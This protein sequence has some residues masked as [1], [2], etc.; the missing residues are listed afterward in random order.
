MRNITNLT[1]TLNPHYVV[2][3]SYNRDF[4]IHNISH[5]AEIEKKILKKTFCNTSGTKKDSNLWLASLGGLTDEESN[6]TI[7]KLLVQEI[8]Q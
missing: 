2:G 5:S 4:F 1:A 6:E 8:L 7:R 3:T